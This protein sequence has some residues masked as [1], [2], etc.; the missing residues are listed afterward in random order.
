MVGVTSK[1]QQGIVGSVTAADAQMGACVPA[2]TPPRAV[3]VPVCLAPPM[4]GRVGVGCGGEGRHPGVREQA[5]GRAGSSASG[6]CRF[7]PLIQFQAG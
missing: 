4:G 7:A 6:S 2:L 3:P 1:G 5:P